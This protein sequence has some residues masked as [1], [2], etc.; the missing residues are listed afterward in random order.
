[1]IVP[2]SA[3]LHLA[4]DMTLEAWVKPS[5]VSNVWR[6]VIYKGDDNYFLEAASPTGLR[7]R[8]HLRR[9]TRRRLR[10]GRTPDRNVDT[11]RPHVQRVEAAALRGWR[12]GRRR[13]ERGNVASSSAPLEIGGDGITGSTSRVP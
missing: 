3:S 5:T 7:C 1:V 11:S 9:R 8:R 13:L 4:N 6:D 10:P 2:D 12:K